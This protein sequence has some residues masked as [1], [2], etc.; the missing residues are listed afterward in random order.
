ML[1][2]VL[3]FA[4]IAHGAQ[5]RKY[6]GEPYITHPIAVAN[7]V[8]TVPHTQE[9]LAAAL[10]HD[11]VEDTSVQL[12]EIEAKFG[13]EI[14]KLVEWLTDVNQHVGNRKARKALDRERLAKA[15]AEVQTIKL[16]DLIHNTKSI[17]QHDPG[18]WKVYKQEKIAL[19]DVLTKGDRSLMHIAQQQIGGS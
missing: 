18:F 14:A 13:G 11:V 7:L 6:T 16:A 3:E 5:A 8:E 4:R 15:P 17:E 2:E 19:L 12:F 1:D 10:L 9:M